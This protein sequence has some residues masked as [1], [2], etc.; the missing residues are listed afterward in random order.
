MEIIQKLENLFSP[1]F[2][3]YNICKHKISFV[4]TK[5]ITLEV[6][7]EKVDGSMDLDTCEIVS[8]NLSDILD[9]NDL[10]SSEYNLDVCSF[11]AEREIVLDE[12][13]SY[14]NNYVHIDYKNPKLGLD[15]VEGTLINCTDENVSVL[16]LDKGK[17]KTAIVEINNIKTIRLAVKI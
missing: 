2:E 1:V 12:I 14:V 3:Q 16:Y 6:C 7:I 15:K 11:G 17:E 13:H 4:Q 10:I 9:L 8:K 5:P